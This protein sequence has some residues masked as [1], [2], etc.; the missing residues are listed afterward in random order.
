[1]SIINLCTNT[2]GRL[3]LSSLH[4]LSRQCF[5]KSPVRFELLFSVIGPPGH[6]VNILSLHSLLMYHFGDF[7]L[8]QPQWNVEVFSQLAQMFLVFLPHRLVL[9]LSLPVLLILSSSWFPTSISLSPHPLFPT[10]NPSSFFSTTS[11]E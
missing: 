4:A 8:S 7:N 11:L 10:D 9:S 6:C 2:L 3:A 5:H 1:M